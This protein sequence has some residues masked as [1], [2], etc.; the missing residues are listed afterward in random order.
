LIAVYNAFS[1]PERDTVIEM[2]D[3]HAFS[4]YELNAIVISA[5]STLGWMQQLK[6]G[7]VPTGFMP[8]DS[9][10]STYGLSL[11]SY[12]HFFHWDAVT[13]ISDSNYNTPVLAELFQQLPGVIYSNAVSISFF[14]H[15]DITIT[16]PFMYNDYTQV[17]YYYAISEA[18]GRGWLFNVYPGCGVEFVESFGDS[19]PITKTEESENN[20]IL[21]RPNPFEDM[22]WVDGY[23]KPFDYWI[24]N[25]QGIEVM[26]GNSIHHSIDQLNGLVPGF[27]I[28]QLRLEDQLSTFTLIKK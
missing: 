7:I 16:F 6:N 26:N 13:F 3:I 22:I 28:L 17:Y 18:S 1:I 19:L 27:Y 14:A 10:L 11:D 21:I 12:S 15:D 2:L 4:D 9:L 5:D 24:S 25:L 20:S 23:E 8:L